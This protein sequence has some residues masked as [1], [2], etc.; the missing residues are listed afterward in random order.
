MTDEK[1]RDIDEAQGFEFNEET[2]E[3]DPIFELTDR[4]AE[5]FGCRLNR[6]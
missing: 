5:H 4:P 2:Q 6:Y 1:E 3:W